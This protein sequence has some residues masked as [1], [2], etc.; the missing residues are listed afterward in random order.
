[1]NAIFIL[2]VL[3]LILVFVCFI[4][5]F[6]ILS[7]LLKVAMKKMKRIEKAQSGIWLGDLPF[8]FVSVSSADLYI[9]LFIVRSHIG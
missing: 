2:G 7:V 5:A 6:S 1:M 4:F 9:F 3:G 8:Q